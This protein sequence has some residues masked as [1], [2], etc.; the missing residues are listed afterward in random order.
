[1]ENKENDCC[2]NG[3]NSLVDTT[4][5][6]SI[7]TRTAFRMR[8]KYLRFI[9]MLTDRVPQWRQSKRANDPTNL[10]P[11]LKDRSLGE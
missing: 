8:H 9:E 3:S 6:I 11:N 7:S 5:E 2:A 4:T 1:M 10:K